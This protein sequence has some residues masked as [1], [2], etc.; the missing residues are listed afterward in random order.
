MDSIM[1]VSVRRYYTVSGKKMNQKNF[2]HNF[3]KHKD[4]VVIL[5]RNVVKVM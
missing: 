4:I 3:D 1:A 2:G 5:A